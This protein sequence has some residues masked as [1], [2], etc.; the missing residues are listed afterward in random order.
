M[1]SNLKIL[2]SGVGGASSSEKCRFCV[3]VCFSNLL[4][5]KSIAN[6]HVW[7]NGKIEK[8]IYA[9]KATMVTGRAVHQHPHYLHVF[10]CCAF[11]ENFGCKTMAK[12]LYFCTCATEKNICV[13]GANFEDRPAVT[14]VTGQFCVP[15]AF[16]M[17]CRLVCSCAYTCTDEVGQLVMWM[18]S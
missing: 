8:L 9:L 15:C 10:A 4:V 11:F 7:D 18:R 5:A 14:P 3:A 12:C 13:Q 6:A 1:L 16:C 2:P 17:R